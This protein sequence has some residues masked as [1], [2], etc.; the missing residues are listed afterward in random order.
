M[1]DKGEEAGE[2]E[3][4][5]A[6]GGT[7]D[8]FFAIESFVQASLRGLCF[9]RVAR[10]NSS[11]AFDSGGLQRAV[12]S[13]PVDERADTF[14]DACCRSVARQPLQKMAVCKRDGH[15]AFLHRQVIA[16]RRLAELLFDF[17]DEVEQ[18]LRARRGRY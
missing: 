13:I 1:R 5:A 15:V 18:V 4:K 16:P 14:A 3:A 17:G 10:Q 11:V 8:L 2:D 12:R 6:V 7:D 9:Q